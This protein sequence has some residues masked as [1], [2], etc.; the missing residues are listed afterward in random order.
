MQNPRGDLGSSRLGGRSGELQPDRPVFNDRHK[1]TA[2]MTAIV[3]MIKTAAPA[4]V[5]AS[6]TQG[7]RVLG[8]P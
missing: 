5:P 1:T 3:T 6:V 8:W 2:D 4:N 7:L